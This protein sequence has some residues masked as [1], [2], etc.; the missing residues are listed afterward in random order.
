M[1]IGLRPAWIEYNK[2]TVAFVSGQS[3]FAFAADDGVWRR[4]A[5]LQLVSKT[6]S[7]VAMES[8]A[9]SGGQ[10]CD[11]LR[12]GFA[13]QSGWPADLDQARPE[14]AGKLTGALAARTRA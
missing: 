5:T 11:W 7:L 2:D 8:S 4:L 10:C 3:T 12:S 13:A 14:A 1:A 9:V 6:A